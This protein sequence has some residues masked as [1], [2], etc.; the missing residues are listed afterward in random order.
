MLQETTIKGDSF[1][2][3]VDSRGRTIRKGTRTFTAVVDSD[4]TRAINEILTLLPKKG[5]SHP[6]IDECYVKDVNCVVTDDVHT[7]L[8]T[9]D[10]ET[11]VSDDTGDEETDVIFP[12]Q[13]EAKITFSSDATISEPIEK[14][15]Y[16]WTNPLF[17][18][19]HPETMTA[20]NVMTYFPENTRE[21]TA[22][23]ARMRVKNTAGD[24]FAGL[25]EEPLRNVAM[26]ISFNIKAYTGSSATDRKKHKRTI[27]YDLLAE[28]YTVNNTPV[29]LFGYLFSSYTGYITDMDITDEFFITKR[30]RKYAYYAVT[31]TIVNNL[32]TWIRRIMNLGLNKIITVDGR[33]VKERIKLL[34]SGILHDITEPVPID[35]NSTPITIDS[36]GK[37]IDP[38]LDATKRVCIIPYLT[39]QPSTWDKLRTICTEVDARS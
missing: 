32:H 31:F 24:K 34:D 5:S 16:T 3:S 26:K 38:T 10:Y 36:D 8:A 28:A 4:G 33:Q 25:P 14:A 30:G 2:F 17:D 7:Y 6:E 22:D 19:D 35:E 9:I 27:L 12:W 13:E 37:I 15:Y 23:L 21:G 29:E 20:E 18:L 1:G 11:R 39:K